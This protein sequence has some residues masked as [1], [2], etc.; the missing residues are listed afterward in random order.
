MQMYAPPTIVEGRYNLVSDVCIRSPSVSYHVKLWFSLVC[1]HINLILSL[2]WRELF[3]IN[4]RVFQIS[5]LGRIS[6]FYGHA[7]VKVRARN[8]VLWTHILVIFKSLDT[9]DMWTC[10]HKGIREC[11]ESFIV[12]NH[13][14]L[15]Y[16]NIRNKSSRI[17][18][19]KK[20]RFSSGSHNPQRNFT[21][22]KIS[23]STIVM[24]GVFGKC[25]LFYIAAH[26]N[27]SFG[28]FFNL[29]FQSMEVTHV[30]LYLDWSNIYFV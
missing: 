19:L 26:W 30:Q 1:C 25:T 4:Y 11:V 8:V 23:E 16:F 18:T 2:Q 29:F 9:E 6:L 28:C 10:H 24:F 14:L 27:S 21:N 15:Y 22:I 20:S 5:V 3:V 12:L 17:F 7:N 13:F